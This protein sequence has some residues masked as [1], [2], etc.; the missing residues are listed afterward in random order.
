VTDAA[1]PT[2]AWTVYSC[3]FGVYTIPK[4]ASGIRWPS[5]E[6]SLP[7]PAADRRRD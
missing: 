7:K 1:G 5:A 2:Q 4:T 6:V 3:D